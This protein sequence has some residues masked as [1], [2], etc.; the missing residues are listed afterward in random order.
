MLK[1]SFK[2][3]AIQNNVS[4]NIHARIFGEVCMYVSVCIFLL[5]IYL[6]LLMLG[7]KVCICS[8]LLDIPKQFVKTVVLVN[9]TT[10]SG[11]CSNPC[12]LTNLSFPLWF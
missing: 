2:F 9:T 7:H 11:S 12:Q 4:M 1:D 3:G 5:S 8:A 6:G 10:K